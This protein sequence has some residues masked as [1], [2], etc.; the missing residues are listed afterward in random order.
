[1][2]E[3]NKLTEKDIKAYSVIVTN[4][5]DKTLKNL[6][7]KSNEH[8]IEF[9][10]TLLFIIDICLSVLIPCIKDEWGGNE[11]AIN[12]KLRIIIPRLLESL[13]EH[14]PIHTST[15]DIYNKEDLERMSEETEA[16]KERLD[17]VRH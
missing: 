7:A 4:E 8:D 12:K 6:N 15:A 11:K 10:L 17:K 5:V 16:F 1:M 9:S 2:S 3:G 13:E 14:L